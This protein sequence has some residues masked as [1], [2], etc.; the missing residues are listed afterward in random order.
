MHY[1]IL[2]IQNARETSFFPAL[3]EFFSLPH[4]CPGFLVG[5]SISEDEYITGDPHPTSHEAPNKKEVSVV[6]VVKI[7][8]KVPARPILQLIRPKAVLPSQKSKVGSPA[9]VFPS[10]RYGRR[11]VDGSSK[12]QTNKDGGEKSKPIKC[13]N[14][15]KEFPSHTELTDHFQTCIKTYDFRCLKCDFS[16]REFSPAMLDHQQREHPDAPEYCE[17]KYEGTFVNFPN[18]VPQG[19][20][21]CLNCPATFS[22]DSALQCHVKSSCRKV[23]VCA[24]CKYTMKALSSMEKHVRRHESKHFL[25]P[26]LLFTKLQ[27]Q[28]QQHFSKS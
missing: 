3:I 21:K 25:S 27:Q 5:Y 14:C 18:R 12:L 26:S 9:I 22:R 11:A 8:K 2:F 28:Q 10:R 17:A 19:T 7:V 1:V 23:Y 24:I 13:L 15:F 16:M 6:E 4:V 20:L